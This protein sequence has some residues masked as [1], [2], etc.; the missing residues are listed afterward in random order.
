MTGKALD[1]PGRWDGLVGITGLL[2]D[3]FHGSALMLDTRTLEDWLGIEDLMVNAGVDD[4]AGV[5]LSIE[6]T[7]VDT[8][9]GSIG[10]DAGVDKVTSNELEAAKDPDPADPSSVLV[11]VDAGVDLAGIDVVKLELTGVD[12][13]DVAVELKLHDD[14]GKDEAELDPIPNTDDGM[15]SMDPDGSALV[16]VL[17]LALQEFAPTAPYV[18]DSGGQMVVENGIVEYC[19]TSDCDCG[20]SGVAGVCS[21]VDSGVDT[22]TGVVFDCACDS[23]SGVHVEV[24]RVEVGDE[25]DPG[26]S[27]TDE[28]GQSV[29]VSSQ[30]VTVTLSV[31]YSVD[32]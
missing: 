29:T 26:A 8:G 3:A 32:S 22:D 25:T 24:N 31:A 13:I 20:C 11:S 23:G 17:L 2:E 15:G 16:L 4:K 6:L 18:E 28:A 19:T 27:E 14:P 21:G 7:E 5:D 1:V 9:V 12:A 10:V 30:L